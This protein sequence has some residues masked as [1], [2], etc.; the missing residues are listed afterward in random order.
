M[1]KSPCSPDNLPS[2]I[3]FCEP[4]GFVGILDPSPLTEISLP[5]VSGSRS[6]LLPKTDSS[7][8]HRSAFKLFEILHFQ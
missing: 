2:A 1:I 3:L 4:L 6:A 8:S 5:A 7:F